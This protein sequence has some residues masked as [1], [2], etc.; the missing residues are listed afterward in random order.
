MATIVIPFLI[1]FT[2]L[3]T[4][5]GI[6]DAAPRALSALAVLTNRR[7]YCLSSRNQIPTSGLA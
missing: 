7:S 4:R 3:M 5:S 2:L 6:R 1:S